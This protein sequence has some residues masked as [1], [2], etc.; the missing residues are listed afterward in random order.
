[1]PTFQHSMT[2]VAVHDMP[3]NRANNADDHSC[4]NY[5][6]Q[7]LD[8]NAVRAKN[9]YLVGFEDMEPH[10]VKTIKKAYQNSFSMV[11]KFDLM[12]TEFDDLRRKIFELIDTK[13]EK[14]RFETRGAL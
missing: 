6:V 3:T 9:G 4:E 13:M 8:M 7:N 14:V 2:S 12:K 1:M 10:I 5:S 11:E